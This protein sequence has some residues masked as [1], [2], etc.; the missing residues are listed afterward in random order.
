VS[1]LGTRA[2]ALLGLD[3]MPVESFDLAV[4]ALEMSTST[5]ETDGPPIM[6]AAAVR[7]APE[8]GPAR[9]A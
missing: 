6:R 8:G 5:S 3:V 7:T 1:R 2:R 4:G 9:L